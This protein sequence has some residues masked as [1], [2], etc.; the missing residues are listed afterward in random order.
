M[1]FLVKPLDPKQM[2]PAIHAALE[3]ANDISHLRDGAAMLADTLVQGRGRQSLIAIGLL[4]ERHRINCDDALDMLHRR[5]RASGRPVED[6]A[7]ELIEQEAR[8]VRRGLRAVPPC[9]RR[10]PRA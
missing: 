6:V 5:A 10:P 9:S 4:V 3:R 2:I 1:G 8:E 7:L